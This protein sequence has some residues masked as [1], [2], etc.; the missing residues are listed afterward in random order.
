MGFAREDEKSIRRGGFL[1][2]RLCNKFGT[3]KGV[4]L[5]ATLF[6]LCWL[7]LYKELGR[8]EI[9]NVRSNT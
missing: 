1:N 2:K 4:I 6:H 7:P 9:R 5:Q 3:V 8:Y